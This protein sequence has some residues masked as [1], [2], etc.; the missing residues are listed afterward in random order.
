MKSE[1][2]LGDAYE[3]IKQVPDKSV[4]L[5]YTDIPYDFEGNGGGGAFGSKKRNYHSEYEKVAQNTE[6]S[7]IWQRTAKSFEG[8]KEIAFGID[9]K[10]LD[11]LVRVMKKINIYIRCSKK[12]ILPLMKYF[13]DKHNCNFDLLVWH[14]TNPIPTV[15]N[16][17]LSDLEYCLLFREEGTSLNYGTY[18]TKS[19]FYQSGLNTTDKG[20][21][22]HPTCKPVELIERHISNSLPRDSGA[23]VLD[24]FSGSGSTLIA[25]KHLGLNYIGFEIDPKWYQV[26]KDRLEGFDQNGE[27]NLF[28]L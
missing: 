19:K 26:A 3:L 18:A 5:V 7:G 12:Q 4:D 6:A 21:Y 13:I 15:N 2:L 22:L 11:E 14:K 27:M 17:Y 8:L 10:I 1:L 9:E 20:K 23:V 16:K 28:D 24:P 25:A